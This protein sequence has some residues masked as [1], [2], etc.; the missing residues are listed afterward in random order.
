MPERVPELEPGK[1]FDVYADE[2]KRSGNLLVKI[3]AGLKDRSPPDWARTDGK[4]GASVN[5]DSE[6]LVYN[7]KRNFQCM[8]DPKKLDAKELLS[9][10]EEKG[11]GGI[12]G[13]F[14]VFMEKG[15]SELVVI[16]DPILP[17]QSW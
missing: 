4:P 11:I 16:T 12:K 3:Q 13:Y 14:W 6:I 5:Y 8:L 1:L 17:A 9:V 10:I 15:K 2:W 7:E